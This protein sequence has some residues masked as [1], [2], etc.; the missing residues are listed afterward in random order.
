MSL[1]P[2][3]RSDCNFNFKMHVVILLQPPGIL[4]FVACQYLHVRGVLRLSS[5]GA[6]LL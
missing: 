4:F 2:N 1:R 5:L 6:R 3:T